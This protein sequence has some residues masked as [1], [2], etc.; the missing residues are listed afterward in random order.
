M[1]KF[2]GFFARKPDHDEKPEAT[3]ATPAN[4]AQPENA[5]ELDEELF[6]TLGAQL[7]S[8]NERLRNLLL[9]ANAKIGELDI[10][11]AAVG[12]LV[13]PVSKALRDIE[14]EKSEKAGLQTLLNN[15][16]TAYGKLRNEVAE[17]EQK[18]AAAEKD[19][20]ELRQDLAS[21]QNLLRA[22]EAAKADM[23]I[24]LA[25]RRAQ[26]V[27]L[28]ARLAHE[29][30]DAKML[31]EDTR[32]LEERL[33]AADKRI[34]AL[35]ADLNAT[36]QRLL[37]AEDEKRAQQTAFEKLSAEAARLSRKLAEA[38]T[39]LAAAMGRLRHVEANFAEAI[40]E[41][42]RLAGSL[43]EANERHGHELA[44]QRMRFDTLQA[45]AAA[46]EKLLV[47]T[48][49][50]L[51]TRAEEIREYDRRVADVARERDALQSRVSELEADRLNRES[52]FH[53]VDQ[54]RAT[55]MERGAALTRAFAA[56]ESALARS[57]ENTASLQER[58]ASL[59]AALTAQSQTAEQTIE[60]L[61]A[62]LRREKVERA[63]IEGALETGRK[64]FARLMREVMALQR[65]QRSPD[66]AD[67]F[68]AA[69]AA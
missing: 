23:A 12:K 48:R 3:E 52:Q 41:R 57:E 13:D 29:S 25:A 26:T 59:E 2:G 45:R 11:K 31:R 37:M 64:D 38:E 56:K 40:G 4:A 65:R 16:R 67:A 66:D 36:R 69:N 42:T 5:L 63:V 9:D 53:E 18:A 20:Q 8:E 19:C 46:T 58:I 27:E 14:A 47:E 24:D 10:I 30:G 32:R 54:V 33:A 50:H 55:L 62:A 15:S 6:T 35:E 17:I 39:N 61:N 60:E 34:I 1:S 49:E 43:E 7:G 44:T 21:T 28:E 51:V 22:T 68:Q